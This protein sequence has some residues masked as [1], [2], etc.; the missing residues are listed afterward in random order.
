MR[1]AP[2]TLAPLRLLA[3]L[4]LPLLAARPVGNIHSA[5][6]I[7]SGQQFVLGGGQPGAFR[8]SAQNTG[9]VPVEIRERPQGGGIFGKAV[10]APGQQETLRF[11]AGSTAV[12]LNP[13]RRQARLKL[14]IGGDT[15]LR[16]TYEPVQY[17]ILPPDSTLRPAQPNR[18]K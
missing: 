9:P 3:L 13:S 2:P 18:P 1:F 17:A 7:P 5:T 8:V 11:L 14:I 6:L 4:V 16:M 12:L 10:L 15:N